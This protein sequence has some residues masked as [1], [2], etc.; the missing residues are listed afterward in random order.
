LTRLELPHNRLV[1]IA[2]LLRVWKDQGKK[3]EGGA[4]SECDEDRGSGGSELLPR[5][6]LLDLRHNALQSVACLSSF[7][8]SVHPFV[9]HLQELRLGHNKL[10]STQGLEATSLPSLHTLDLSH[11][12]LAR[13]SEVERLDDDRKAGDARREGVGEGVVRVLEALRLAGTPLSRLGGYRV[14]VLALLRRGG[15]VGILDGLPP[16]QE[17]TR[18]LQRRLTCAAVSPLSSALPKIWAPGQEKEKIEEKKM[19]EEEEEEEEEE[20]RPVQQRLT[21]NGEERVKEKEE[22][23]GEEEEE[24]SRLVI[25]SF[26]SSSSFPLPHSPAQFV[27][28]SK[29]DEDVEEIW[30]W[31]DERKGSQPTSLSLAPSAAFS[32]RPS[33]SSP[34]SFSSPS[35]PASI[36]LE[37]GHAGESGEVTSTPNKTPATA[38]AA[39][40]V[41]S[42]PVAVAAAAPAPPAAAVDVQGTAVPKGR[43]K[44]E[45]LV[46]PA[47]APS[48]TFSASFSSTF[49]CRSSPSSSAASAK[50]NGR[51]R[52]VALVEEGEVGK[53]GGEEWLPTSRNDAL[54]RY[55]ATPPPFLSS[56]PLTDRKKKE[57]ISKKK[58]K[59]E[60]G[61]EGE[62][63]GLG[64]RMEM[65]RQ[66]L[67]ALEARLALARQEISRVEERKMV[68]LG[69]AR[70]GGREGKGKKQVKVMAG[71]A[72]ATAVGTD[73]D[74]KEDVE[75]DV[76]EEEETIAG[77]FRKHQH[78]EHQ[79]HQEHQRPSVASKSPLPSVL[80]VPKGDEQNYKNDSNASRSSSQSN[81]E[82]KGR[83]SSSSSS[84]S[85][86]SSSSLRRFL[87][88][89]D[90]DSI[91]AFLVQQHVFGSPSRS[92]SLSMSLPTPYSSPSSP[93]SLSACFE[94][95]PHR[96]IVQSL[97]LSHPEKLLHLYKV[98]I[99]FH[100]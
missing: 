6:S 41:P 55:L 96:S 4:A 27:T 9:A 83:S 82:H 24:L 29:S 36:F 94:I 62:G 54:G 37:D 71:K 100:V 81:S 3:K 42:P 2:G 21:G 66:E 10:R 95:D 93:T 18:E 32:S 8:S 12:P 92:A 5:L 60:R 48:L 51:P 31:E 68:V 30:Q 56:L 65:M 58:K 77:R 78:Q 50:R 45:V 79:E 23:E 43:E 61:Q 86:S 1:S 63:E 57:K 14:K 46:R 28:T 11:N 53:A 35:S 84:S 69:E 13:W 38:S 16:S 47:T 89:H 40:V 22:E 67:A 39:A 64:N 74:V 33:P 98:L 7:H 80:V 88:P 52:R 97:A 44:K 19:E 26:A 34:P 91:R 49:S 99:A 15:G 72:L 17:E 59:K 90:L 25:P 85:F 20:A 75:E 76:G 70:G 87:S 73:G